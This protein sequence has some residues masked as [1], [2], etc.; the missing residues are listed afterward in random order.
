M[1]SYV[2]RFFPELRGETVCVGL[3]RGAEGRALVGSP[4]IWLN[5]RG[6]TYHTIAH[7]LVHVLQGR[8]EIPGGERSCDVFALARH[9]SLADARPSYVRVPRW[10]F[11][12]R[13]RPLPRVSRTLTATALD[14][15]ER[16]RAGR[17]RYI[18]WFE[19]EVE[20]RLRSATLLCS[21]T[22]R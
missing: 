6:L 10:A 12:A 9:P 4:R 18:R 2:L 14:A 8:T 20:R 19:L 1:T 17:R 11:D 5:P 3:A 7:E 22:P 13:G 21:S 15:L 16:R